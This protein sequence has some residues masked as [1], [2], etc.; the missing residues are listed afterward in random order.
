[1]IKQATK[2]KDF[3]TINHLNSLQEFKNLTEA[4]KWIRGGYE[5]DLSMIKIGLNDLR[6]VRIK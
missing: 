5:H 3:F 2:E 6:K 1:M 4:K